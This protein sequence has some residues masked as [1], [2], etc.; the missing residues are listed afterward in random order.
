MQSY[1]IGGKYDYYGTVDPRA[2][3]GFPARKGSTYRYVPGVGA[4]ILLQKQDDGLTTSW[5]FVGT[6]GQDSVI[7]QQNGSLVSDANILNFTGAGVA[8]TQTAPGVVEIAI[9]GAGAIAVEDDGAPVDP[10]VTTLNFGQGLTATQTSPGTVEVALATYTANTLAWFDSLGVMRSYSNSS[11]DDTQQKLFLAGGASTVDAT[12]MNSAVVLAGTPFTVGGTLGGNGPSLLQSFMNVGANV[13]IG[14]SAAQRSLLLGDTFTLADQSGNRSIAY[15]LNTDVGSGS[16]GLFGSYRSDS[17]SGIAI[18]ANNGVMTAMLRVQ[19]ATL[20]NRITAGTAISHSFISARSQTDGVV[21]FAN[22]FGLMCADVQNGGAFNA[23]STGRGIFVGQVTGAGSAIQINGQGESFV[24]GRAS[25]GGTIT[26][27]G[28]NSF[29]KAYVDTLGSITVAFGGAV[30]GSALTSGVINVGNASF[31]AAQASTSGS[32]TTSGVRSNIIGFASDSGQLL[33]SAVGGLTLGWAQNSAVIQTTNNGSFAHGFANDV[34]SAIRASNDGAHA[35]GRAVLGGS[36]EA[37]GIGTTAIGAPEGAQAI[38]ISG[39]GSFGGG[40]PSNLG[41]NIS[42]SGF[43]SFSWGDFHTVSG[44]Y[45]QAFGIGQSVDSYLAVVFGR[46]ADVPAGNPNSFVGTDI[47][48][49]YGSGTSNVSRFNAFAIYKNGNM[50]TTG[51]RIAS[52]TQYYGVDSTLAVTDY[53]VFL[54]NDPA[55][56]AYNITMPP[57]VEGKVI[58]MYNIGTQTATILGDGADVVQL[59]NVAAG[60]RREYLYSGGTWYA[61]SIS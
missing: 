57:G 4:A 54:Q 37:S 47:G 3:S 16:G 19:T 40:R 45:A 35:W 36:I 22:S 29:T 8:V 2:G 33:C 43:G 55:D 14:Q 41:G 7:V 13:T 38:I 31:I 48:F 52:N 27:N 20:T 15:L 51:A 42:V 21:N 11:L 34:G 5:T 46:F 39:D 26:V 44:N 18:P 9:S 50:Q 24:H 10:A 60:D 30:F 53:Y 49:A 1:E 32:I 28:G 12:A 56:P 61:F 59:P 25:T 23:V 6:Q 58:K 17:A